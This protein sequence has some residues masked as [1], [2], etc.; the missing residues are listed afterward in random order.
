[1]RPLLSALVVSLGFVGSP[2]A[3]SQKLSDD[4]RVIVLALITPR[5]MGA[6]AAGAVPIANLED[7]LL[8]VIPVTCRMKKCASS[9]TGWD[10]EDSL[11]RP[12][13]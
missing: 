3:E 11:E 10:N 12:K 4:I 2:L 6:D 5:A 9:E 7:T 8:C 13:S 1:M